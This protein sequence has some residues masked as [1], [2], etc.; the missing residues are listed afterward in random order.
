L[1]YTN[2]K[3]RYHTSLVEELFVKKEDRR[4]RQEFFKSGLLIPEEERGILYN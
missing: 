3:K 4:N 2:S 1:P